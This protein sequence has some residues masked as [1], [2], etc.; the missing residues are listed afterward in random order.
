[1]TL[2]ATTS[3]GAPGGTGT[4]VVRRPG[5][6]LVAAAA[7]LVLLG[8]GVAEAG[9]V[10][11]PRAD[12]R[13]A[14]DR[15]SLDRITVDGRVE[16]FR[17]PSRMAQVLTLAPLPLRTW[18]GVFGV[19]HTTIGHWKDGQEPDRDQLD[20]VL[21]ALTEAAPFHADLASW[22]QAALPGTDIRPLDL[23][24]DERWTAFRGAIRVQS[25]PS[26]GLDGDE[27]VRRRRAQ[28]SW[29]VPEVPIVVDA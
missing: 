29:A 1:M 8:S 5:S 9:T 18:A 6:T 17:A 27:L 28:V 26:V 10:V 19:T 16:P 15:T 4:A 2:P 3:L 25:A 14:I 7:T 22:L 12:L 20:R 21:G 11:T 24:R 23:L 13:P